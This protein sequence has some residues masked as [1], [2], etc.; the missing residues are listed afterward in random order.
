MLKL[1]QKSWSCLCFEFFSLSIVYSK[2]EILSFGKTKGERDR[3]KKKLD[4]KS[5]E[6][7]KKERKKEE[8]N[9]W[10]LE[11]LPQC[12]FGVPL[13]TVPLSLKTWSVVISLPAS[14]ETSKTWTK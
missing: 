4:H 8:K 3:E 5:E 13:V 10:V 7:K 12:F 11:V 2:A 14:L 6:E 9:S 1:R